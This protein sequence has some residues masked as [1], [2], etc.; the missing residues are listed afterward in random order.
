MGRSIDLYSYDYEPLVE[1]IKEYVS[2]D[3]TEVIRKILS[4]GGSV[5][6]DK[7]I[8]LNNELWDE[9]SPYYNVAG[10]LE[11]YFKAED[12]FGEIFC[13]LDHKFGRKELINACDPPE[14]ILFELNMSEEDG[15]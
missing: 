11:D 5:I 7:Y 14:E 13:T 1:G 6:G 10:A 2:A 9:C 3:N 12:V 15:E 8:I 4:V